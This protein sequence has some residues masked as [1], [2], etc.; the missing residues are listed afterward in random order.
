VSKVTLESNANEALNDYFVLKSNVD[1][2][3]TNDSFF[4]VTPMKR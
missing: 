1:D 4:Q 2:A 3:L